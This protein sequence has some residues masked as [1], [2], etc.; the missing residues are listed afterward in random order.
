MSD[1]DIDL[2]VIAKDTGAVDEILSSHKLS[3]KTQVI[4]KTQPELAGW[5]EKNP[6]FYKEIERGITLSEEKDEP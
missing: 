3:R 1:S 4:I 5:R 2:F 6:V